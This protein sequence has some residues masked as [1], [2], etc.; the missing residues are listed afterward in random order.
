[1]AD[2]LRA[3]GLDW[4]DQSRRDEV[5]AYMVAPAS[6]MGSSGDLE[7]I[8]I[9]GG[10][11]DAEYYT[12]GRVSAKVRYEGSSWQR[13]RALRLDL[14]S[15]LGGSTSTRTLGTFLVTSDDG[16]YESGRWVGD[17]TCQSMLWATS[18]KKL[19]SPLTVKKGQRVREV[20]KSLLSDCCRRYVVR[21]VAEHGT[22]AD[23]KVYE[24][25]KTYAD[26]LNDLSEMGNIR[27]DVDGMGFV[28]LDEWLLPDLRSP[29]FELSVD[30]PRG[31][32]HDSIS[33]ESDFAELPSEVVIHCKYSEKV[34]KP[35]GVYQSNS[36]RQEDGTYKHRKGD[37]KYKETSEQRE[38]NGVARV[39][40]GPQSEAER[41]FAL[42]DFR[43]I[44]D[45]ELEPKTQAEID[46]RARVAL[47]TSM[48]GESIRWTVATQYFPVWEGDVGHI[49]IPTEDGEG[50]RRVKVFVRALS[51]DLASM[52]LRLTLQETG[53]WN[54]EVYGLNEKGI[55]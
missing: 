37:P 29:T 44:E 5:Y 14:R 40:G 54:E 55:D 9:D 47:A 39:S 8:R 36:E 3:D 38:L 21:T 15:T 4:R 53:A 46:R 50:R 49:V 19:A 11:V 52:Q 24:S 51:L 32:L 42:T 48:P 35:D 2:L 41:G 10:S 20:I 26:V 6:L 27:L 12:A 7:D 30:D 25:G 31:L 34:Q 1:M 16:A 33:R 13:N 23:D 28:T 45:D 17:L 22:F 43:T 18:K